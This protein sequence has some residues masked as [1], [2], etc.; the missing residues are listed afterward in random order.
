MDGTVIGAYR[1]IRK[2]GEGGMGTV[3]LGEHTLLGRQAAIKVLLPKVSGNDEIVQRFFNEARAVTRISDPGVVQV[4][5]FGYADDGSAFIVMELLAGEAMDQRLARIG[6]FS[7]ADALRL[8]RLAC[9]SLGAAHA[10][11]I[12]HR[13]LKPENLYIVDDPGVTG[14]ERVKILDFGIAKLSGDDPG[15]IKT[16]TGVLMGTPV[17]MSPEQCRGAGE[18]DQRSD[19]Y[20]MGCVLFAM[21]AGKPPFFGDA[22]GELI[23]AHLR[24]PA[25]LVSSRVQVA[26]EVDALVQRCLE[27]QLAARFQTMAEVV[28]AIDDVLGAEPSVTTL[29]TGPTKL[30]AIAAPAVPTST[31]AGAE[32]TELPRSRRGLRWLGVAGG[33]VVALAIAIVATT[34]GRHHDAD[35]PALAPTRPPAEAAPIVAAPAIADAAEPP[36]AEPDAALA[37]TTVLPDAAPAR[38]ATHSGHHPRPGGNHAKPATPVPF[39]RS[40]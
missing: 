29:Q 23:V 18:V 30:P 32:I 33:V 20:A 2:I 1:V 37:T 5:D 14:G 39:D 6:T 21:L 28:A 8:A 15:A 4:F 19:I 22:S 26:P 10:K 9:A 27:K 36:A 35:T 25:P 7:V 24:E 34:S 17:F 13:D 31:L 12:I 16:R 11:G 38:A 3:Y 40:D